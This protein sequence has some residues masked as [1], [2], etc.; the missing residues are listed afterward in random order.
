[1]DTHFRIMRLVVKTL[2]FLAVS[3]VLITSIPSIEVGELSR[4]LDLIS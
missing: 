4:I 2:A 3:V 1:M